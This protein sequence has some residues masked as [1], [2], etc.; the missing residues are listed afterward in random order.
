MLNAVFATRPRQDWLASLEAEDVPFAPEYSLDE[1]ADD[2]QI[3]HLDVFY[4]VEHPKYGAVRAP[5]RAVRVDGSR[6]VGARAAARS[7]GST[8]RKSWRNWGGSGG[9]RAGAGNACRVEAC[10]IR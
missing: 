5:H 1:L 9:L 6:E 3:A 2:P 10:R 4:T 8:R 7:G